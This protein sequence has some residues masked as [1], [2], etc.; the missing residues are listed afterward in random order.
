MNTEDPA[1]KDGAD[2]I[3]LSATDDLRVRARC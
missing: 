2:I 1:R 3:H